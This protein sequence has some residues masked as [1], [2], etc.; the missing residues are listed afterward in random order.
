MS[1]FLYVGYRKLVITSSLII[2]GQSLSVIGQDYAGTLSIYNAIPLMRLS[3]GLYD[4]NSIPNGWPV[5]E[6]LTVISHHS[7]LI[8]FDWD[9]VIARKLSSVR[10]EVHSVLLFRPYFISFVYSISNIC[11]NKET[12][13]SGLF[14]KNTQPVFFHFWIKKKNKIISFA[15]PDF[16]WILKCF[17]YIFSISV[18][19]G[20]FTQTLSQYSAVVWTLKCNGVVTLNKTASMFVFQ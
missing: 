16:I 18:I 6:S 9:V 10:F 3:S 14:C 1:I 20:C 2:K 15:L 8:L 11:C 17:I 4:S 7:F 13:K 12:L 19:S 5:S